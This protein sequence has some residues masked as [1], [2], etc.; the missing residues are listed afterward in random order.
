MHDLIL[1]YLQL[2]PLEN[3]DQK[4]LKSTPLVAGATEIV[5]MRPK[6]QCVVD[7]PYVALFLSVLTPVVLVKHLPTLRRRM[8]KGDVDEPRALIVH[9]CWCWSVRFALVCRSSRGNRFGPGSTRRVEKGSPTRAGTRQDAVVLHTQNANETEGRSSK[10]SCRQ[11][12][13]AVFAQRTWRGRKRLNFVTE[14]SNFPVISRSRAATR[15]RPN[16]R[17]EG[18]ISRS[19]AQ[20]NPRLRSGGRLELGTGRARHR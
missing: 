3:L 14:P 17:R 15:W 4:N 8:R 16:V 20:T 5:S 18:G 9:R 12:I 6:V 10:R 13:F 2:H 7:L 19:P 11:R 1:S